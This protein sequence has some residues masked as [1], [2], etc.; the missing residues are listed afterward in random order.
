[1][2]FQVAGGKG[3]PADASAIV[4][5]LTVTEPTSFGFITAYATGRAKPNTS[6]LNYGAGQTVPNLAIVPVGAGG[7]VTLVNTS[8]GSVQLVADV[9]AY[10]RAATGPG[11]FKALVP[12]RILDTRSSTGAVAARGAVS[13][14]VRGMAGIPAGASAVVMNLTVTE[15][16]SFGFLTVYP[17]GTGKPSASNVNYSAGQ[18]VPN[19]VVVPVGADGNVTVSNTSSGSAQVVADVSG[20]FLTG[21]PIQPG[22]FG[23]LAA[24]RFLDTRVSSGRV[25][26]GGSVAFQVRG[27]QGIPVNTVAV[28]VNLTVTEAGSYG[29]LTAFAS[30]SVMP[31]TSNL[32]YARDQTVPNLAVVPVGADGKVRITNTSGGAVQVIADVSGYVLS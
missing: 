7:R 6:N 2:S 32:N 15:P 28:V 26:A 3:V 23:Y 19:L 27:V 18:T 14:K 25:A 9:S 29:F 31:N 5:N 24:T 30:G 20:Y 13:V 1:V 4:V 17:S 10:F 16:R 11:A 22:A 8:A 12:T 21:T